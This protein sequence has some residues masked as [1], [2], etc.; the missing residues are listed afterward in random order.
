MLS[1][2]AARKTWGVKG[3][4]AALTQYRRRQVL[5][6]GQAQHV[7]DDEMS[8]EWN[9]QQAC[10]PPALSDTSLS[11]PIPANPPLRVH[12]FALQVTRLV[13]GGLRDVTQRRE[14][15]AAWGSPSRH[16]IDPPSCR[17]LPDDLLRE[18]GDELAR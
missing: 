16:F 18:D 5:R 14:L 17:G 12:S 3:G 8:D 6:W 13:G 4:L 2:Q 9:E 1:P 11:N 15:A 10:T 7:F